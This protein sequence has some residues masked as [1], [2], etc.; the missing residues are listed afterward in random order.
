MTGSFQTSIG[1]FRLRVG[2]PGSV[3]RVETVPP[4]WNKVLRPPLY[5][6]IKRSGDGDGV[7]RSGSAGFGDRVRAPNLAGSCIGV[8]RRSLLAAA[9]H[10][11]TMDG[12][13][14]A[15][16]RSWCLVTPRRQRV[17]PLNRRVL[18]CVPGRCSSLVRFFCS[19]L[20][21]L[22]NEASP[23]FGL[24]SFR[25]YLRRRYRRSQRRMTTNGAWRHKSSKGPCYNFSFCMDFCV[26]LSLLY[27]SRR[28]CGLVHVLRCSI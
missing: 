7:V 12:L 14:Y 21:P 13:V 10:R 28:C 11:R 26:H 19:S 6:A 22:G 9:H 24:L 20:K 23:V 1:P 27:T 3:L 25:C 5:L 8:V 17:Q 16:R 4:W 18:G 2:I 15:W